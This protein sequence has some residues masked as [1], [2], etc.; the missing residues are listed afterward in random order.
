MALSGKFIRSTTAG[1]VVQAFVPDPLPPE[2]PIRLEE[3]DW[4]LY[5]RANR[6]LGRLDGVTGLL[7]DPTL[8]IYFYI[9]KEAV[10]SSQIEGTQSSLSELLVHENNETPGVP[11]DE[12]TEVSNYVAAM[13]YGLK[14]LRED[15]F[16]ISL[17]LM[18]EIHNVLLE[19]GRGADKTPGEF[20]TSQNWI[21]G[22]RPGNAHFVPPPP[23]R[24]IECMGNLEL[25]I[26]GNPKPYPLLIKTAL[27]HVQFET[28]HPFLDGNGRL[29]R[30]LVTLLLCA[31][32]ALTEPL[33]YLS[34]FFKQNRQ[35][36]YDRLQDVRMKGNWLGWLRFFLKGVHETAQG[37]VQTSRRI[38]QQF[39]EDATKVEA[40]GT[41]AKST[42]RILR[43]LQRKPVLS[44]PKAS[45]ELDLSA[46]TVRSAVES[47]V[48]LGILREV[49]G[50]Q[51]DRVYIYDPYVKILEEGTE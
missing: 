17:R 3:E 20:R 36:Y 5:E 34:L 1:E 2:P 51:R 28:I 29:G 32:D 48:N 40:L 30:L 44:V 43:G 50:K 27:A 12:I 19:K 35:E 24:V 39:E 10:L 18:K 26:H 11:L 41:R 25:F 45:E 38:L 31:E 46:P 42:P 16:P 47:L 6:A 7:P 15:D 37:A 14:R 13:E 22:S 21:G 33:L 8:F 4:D 23:D 49:T 9:R